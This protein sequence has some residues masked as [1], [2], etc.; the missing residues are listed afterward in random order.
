MTLKGPVSPGQ[1][2]KLDELGFEL[3]PHPD[4]TVEVVKLHWNFE[5]LLETGIFILYSNRNKVC[6]THL[7]RALKL[8]LS[9][10]Y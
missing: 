9:W 7:P 1:S 2:F 10:I 6:S 5:I 4:F 8:F 3:L